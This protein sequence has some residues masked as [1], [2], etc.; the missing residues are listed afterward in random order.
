MKTTS[1][2]NQ[3]EI[4][5]YFQ[6]LLASNFNKVH[7]ESFRDSSNALLNPKDKTHLP[8]HLTSEEPTS[9]IE[10]K[11]IK[12]HRNSANFQEKSNRN[13][14][15]FQDKNNHLEENY[16]ADSEQA[17]PDTNNINFTNIAKKIGDFSKMTIAS[18]EQDFHDEYMNG[19][20]TAYRLLNFSGSKSPYLN[21]MKQMI[22]FNI[23]MIIFFMTFLS[24]VTLVL[25]TDYRLGVLDSS[26]KEFLIYSEWAIC[27]FFC[28]EIVLSVLGCEG[29]LFKKIAHIFVFNN[30][31]NI[32]SVLEIITTTIY[33]EDLTHLNHFFTIIFV[34]RSFK[35]IKLRMIIQYTLKQL[36]KAIINEK[37]Q[38]SYDSQSE[39]KYFVYNSA[40]DITVA[41]FIEATA[42]MAIDE[43]LNY[44]AFSVGEKG[45]FDYITASY[46]SIVSL[47]S[48]GYGDI[49][50]MGW[51]CRMYTI[52]VLFFN[53]SV[54]SNFL[55]AMTDKIYQ[56]SPYIRNFYYKDHIVIIGELPLTFMKYFIKELHLCD[57]VT[58]NIYSQD[59]STKRELS[60]IILVGDE[61]PTKEMEKWLEDFSND[62]IEIH[63]LKSNVMGSNW[64][65]QTNLS[66]AR[67][68]FAFSM[69]F[70]ED[71]AQSFE[72]D[73]QM[74]YNMQKVVNSYQ[75]LEITLV[76][77]TE[78][79]SQ[80]KNDSLFSRVTVISAQILNEYLMANS[81]ENRG[82]NTFLTHLATL[83]E[84]SVPAGS[85]LKN[86]EEYSIN[87]G[88][89]LYP[90]SKNP[91]FFF[92]LS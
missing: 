79:S 8:D 55:T 16:Q 47:T 5:S 91:L 77:S 36:K 48:I 25:I 45:K 87:M 13:S 71:Q 63:Y 85:E 73:K 19:L 44:K 35:L 83:R 33:S 81:L 67:Q 88:Q 27:S 78:F 50:P 74:A 10:L 84:K 38:D 29:G 89:E 66:F 7:P 57:K 3:P 34:L 6:T 53:I 72:S 9:E 37:T 76:L 14:F 15:Q 59:K 52:C 4:K 46:Y 82:M 30:V 69:N 58:K 24:I 11:T 62:F 23:Q 17:N 51:Q 42:F 54:L 22:F 31:C 18:R 90:I 65:K 40:L 41:I 68:I 1:A 28:F 26:F 75:K 80:I 92:F 60:K 49:Y 32:L 61:K 21:A 20:N 43:S 64:H 70:N 39:L 86:L 2:M 56:I 12:N